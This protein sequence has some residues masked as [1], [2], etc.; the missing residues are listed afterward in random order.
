MS[1][2]I[3]PRLSGYYGGAVD[4]NILAFTQLHWVNFDFEF[5]TLFE[6]I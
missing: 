4:S 2:K 5:E 3:V 1:Q 6:S